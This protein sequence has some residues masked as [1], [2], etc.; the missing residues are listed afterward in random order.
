MKK[1]PHIRHD[2][3]VSVH[4]PVV[5]DATTPE[6]IQ[7]L[8]D[9]IG[10][11]E[12]NTSEAVT[13]AEAKRLAPYFT[14]MSNYFQRTLK[15]TGAQQVDL[16][17]ARDSLD[18]LTT[19]EALAGIF[20]AAAKRTHNA[21]ISDVTILPSDVVK[22]GPA[23]YLFAHESQFQVNYRYGGHMFNFGFLQVFEGGDRKKARSS[24]AMPTFLLDK[25][26]M[27]AVAPFQPL[28]ML[29]G[30]QGVI[31][32]VNHDMLH[33]LTSPVINPS[34][35][36][37]F[38]IDDIVKPK[39]KTDPVSVWF[40]TLPSRGLFNYYEDWAQISQEKILLSPGN[41]AQTEAIRQRVTDYFAA[42][43]RIGADIS[44]DKGPEKAHE[45]VDYFGTVMA[46]AL[47]RVFPLDHPVMTH[48]IDSLEKSDPLPQQCLADAAKMVPE[49]KMHALQAF[50]D[51]VAEI[52]TGVKK[53]PP[54]AEDTL[55][56]LRAWTKTK[57]YI[58][59][60][61]QAYRERGLDI[62]PDQDK[63]VQYRN[64]KLLQLVECSS[65]D[66]LPHMPEPPDPVMV[67]VR[68]RADRATLGMV[69]AASK[70]FDYP[71]K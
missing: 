53:P 44:R 12:S 27:K 47:T 16:G 42:I 52:V 22:S 34:V 32:W 14:A 64:L 61:S 70:S 19:P 68:Q 45:V 63:F 18:K 5:L 3:P 10:G 65:P 38:H 4:A 69:T 41:E 56:T 26:M 21:I 57:P 2:L 17:P 28:E 50:R 8:F 66:I 51:Y 46:H 25:D 67:E 36:R 11:L 6:G 23:S 43:K 40:R 13:E 20:N 62:L 35:A 24:V 39:G 31:S 49:K 33:H 48:C 60:I 9:F 37:K 71:A 59:R 15:A 30:F 7:P 1:N 55:T 54:A 29:K 58:K